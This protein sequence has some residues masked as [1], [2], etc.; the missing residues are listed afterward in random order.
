[1][2]EKRQEILEKTESPLK[3]TIGSKLGEGRFGK[4]FKA[5]IKL[6]TKIQIGQSG[7][8]AFTN[9]IRILRLLK[10]ENIIAFLGVCTSGALVMEWMDENLH[11]HIERKGGSLSIDSIM[12]F[13]INIANALEYLRQRRILHLDLKTKNLLV[14]NY[15][16]NVKLSDFG[17]AKELTQYNEEREV[18][19][20][21]CQSYG[22]VPYSQSFKV[23]KSSL[24]SLL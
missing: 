19:H 2:L 14:N 13:G 3:I 23:S 6:A 16:E 7:Q 17:S 5:T 12:G 4:V 20:Y 10:H 11:Q 9:E 22:M 24:S 1:M 21:D 8:S 15:P 18:L